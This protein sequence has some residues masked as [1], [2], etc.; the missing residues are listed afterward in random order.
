MPVTITMATLSVFK[1]SSQS[2]D[3]SLSS[4]DNMLS[5]VVE[6]VTSPLPGVVESV[7]APLLESVTAPLSGVIKPLSVLFSLSLKPLV[8]V[9]TVVV[10][11][12]GPSH[13]AS[14]KQEPLTAEQL[15]CSEQSHLGNINIDNHAHHT[16]YTQTV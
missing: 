7:T 13:P 1:E 2:M 9:G 16:H 4:V 8:G 15:P 3:G 5:G 14:H 6:W 10:L 11:Q 12:V